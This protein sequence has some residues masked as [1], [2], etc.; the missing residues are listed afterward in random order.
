MKRTAIVNL[1]IVLSALPLSTIAIIYLTLPQSGTT[2]AH[3]VFRF[4]LS[5]LTAHVVWRNGLDG[6]IVA[7]PFV[8]LSLGTI[9]STIKCKRIASHV[10]ACLLTALWVFIVLVNV[11]VTLGP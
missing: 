3:H 1:I 7:V 6:A 5:P 8:F 2:V 9:A 10:M 4:I 11:F